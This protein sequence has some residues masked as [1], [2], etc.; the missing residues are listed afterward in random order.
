MDRLADEFLNEFIAIMLVSRDSDWA[1]AGWYQEL[2]MRSVPS[3][4]PVAWEKDDYET[5]EHNPFWLSSVD[6]REGS[7]MSL[8]PPVS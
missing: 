8:P 4:L 3:Y 7:T 5:K 1:Y 6:G 2:L